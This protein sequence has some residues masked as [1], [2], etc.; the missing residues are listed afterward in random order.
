MTA[1]CLASDFFFDFFLRLSFV[2]FVPLIL[3]SLT[4]YNVKQQQRRRWKK[5]AAKRTPTKKKQM[6]INYLKT[7]GIFRIFFVSIHSF[8]HTSY[9]YR[10]GFLTMVHGQWIYSKESYSHAI[11]FNFNLKAPKPLTNQPNTSNSHKLFIYFNI[12]GEIVRAFVI[13]AYSTQSAW[14]ANVTWCSIFCCDECSIYLLI[15]ND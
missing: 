5:G 14:S 1:L 11:Y 3:F 12:A 4:I 10:L 2:S 9:D 7:S 13:Y 8:R 6:K 15:R